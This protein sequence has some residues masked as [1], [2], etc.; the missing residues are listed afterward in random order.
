MKTDESVS[1]SAWT[2]L[3]FVTDHD[4]VVLKRCQNQNGM[5]DEL[6]TI[7]KKPFIVVKWKVGFCADNK[8]QLFTVFCLHQMTRKIS[9][10]Q[11]S[12]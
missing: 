11:I 2:F 3:L 12:S 5:K 6:I 9:P 4:L 7:N 8:D 10:L 1:K